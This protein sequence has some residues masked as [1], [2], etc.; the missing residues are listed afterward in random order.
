MGLFKDEGTWWIQNG[1]ENRDASTK[2][3]NYPRKTC[4]IPSKTMK[5][6]G[7][8]QFSRKDELVAKKNDLFYEI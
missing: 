1:V 3:Q 7:F 2:Y 6:R 5:Q 8:Q 4:Q